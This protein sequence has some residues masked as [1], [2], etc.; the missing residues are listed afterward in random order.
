MEKFESIVESFLAS[1]KINP[2]KRKSYF[3]VLHDKWEKV[4]LVLKHQ[5]ALKYV[6]LPSGNEIWVIMGKTDEYL[7]I[8]GL[9]CSCY[10]FYFNAILRKKD[11]CCYH[12]I[13]QILCEK[14]GKFSTFYKSDD[15]L[16]DY[17]E[18]L[19]DIGFFPIS[20]R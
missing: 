5:N 17:L 10:D 6:F 16:N 4:D 19:L 14:L 20:T 15:N 7:V 9:Y 18:D 11:I 13:A 1:I 12:V 3:K 2:S 8:P